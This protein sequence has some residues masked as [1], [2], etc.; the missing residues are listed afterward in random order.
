MPKGT[1]SGVRN[2][3]I[4]VAGSKGAEYEVFMLG[5][6]PR[7]CTCP[8]FEHRAGPAG[9]DCKHMKARR[10]RRAVG[11]TRCARC[12]KWLSPEEVAWSSQEEVP[13]GSFACAECN[14]VHL[15]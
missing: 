13:Q 15:S 11:S 10:G 14:G 6:Y 9:E 3:R 8:S 12:M 2:F 1:F 4:R 7:A 5:E